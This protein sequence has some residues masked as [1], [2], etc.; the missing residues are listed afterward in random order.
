MQLSKL[1]EISALSTI[2]KPIMLP[3]QMA[4]FEMMWAE[5]NIKDYPYLLINPITDAS[6]QSLPAGPIAYT[7]SPQIPAAMAALLQ[8]TEMDM[9]DLLGKQDAGEQLQPNVSGKAIELVQSRLDMQAFIYMSNMSKAIKRS[10]EVWLSMAK[11]ILVERGRKMKTLNSEYEAGQVEL[12]KPMLNA[13][14]G[15][16]EYENDLREAKFDLS[17]DVGPSSS[18]KRASTVRSITAMMQMTQDPENM[19]ILS[20]MAMMN[21]EGEGLSDVRKFYRKK[22]VQMGVIEPSAQ[23]AAD[24]AEAAQN[25]QPDANAEY[26]RAAAANEV[27]KAEKT[28]A[29]T[30]LSVAKAENT[31]A[32]TMET[33]SSIKS[34]DQERMIKAAEQVREMSESMRERGAMQQRT[35]QQ[36]PQQRVQQLPQREPDMAN[37]STEELINIVRGQ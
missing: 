3:E 26:L 23:E 7:K 9:Q 32:D 18:S 21:M 27:A 12:G 1:A 37:M 4:G 31:K 13:D 14:T 16:I 19:A 5:D 24:I 15:E 11:D 17:V 34:E 20:A 8:I 28:K 2:E 10:G 29:D 33:L 22:L 36:F 35:G 6:G 25:A 30:L